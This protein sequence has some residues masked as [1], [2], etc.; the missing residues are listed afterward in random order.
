[1]RKV[2]VDLLDLKHTE[3]THNTNLLLKYLE[4]V[5]EKQHLLFMVAVGVIPLLLQETFG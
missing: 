1:M 3:Q 4:I 5:K 2:M